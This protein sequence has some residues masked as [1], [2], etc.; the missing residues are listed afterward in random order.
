MGVLLKIFK[1]TITW[2]NGGKIDNIVE[3]YVNG[4]CIRKSHSNR[5]YKY[6]ISYVTAQN[7]F[8]ELYYPI[9]FLKCNNHN[10]GFNAKSIKTFLYSWSWKIECKI[11]CD[12]VLVYFVHFYPDYKGA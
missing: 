5:W 11:S 1:W 9:Y 2:V 7:S 8:I 3:K 6:E 10:T 12:Y 4:F